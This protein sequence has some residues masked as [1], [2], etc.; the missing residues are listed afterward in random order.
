[1]TPL[2][3]D[4]GFQTLNRWQQWQGQGFNYDWYNNTYYWGVKL[5]NSP[6]PAA[7]DVWSSPWFNTWRLENQAPAAPALAAPAAGFRWASNAPPMLTINSNAELEPEGDPVSFR[8]E[9]REPAANGVAYRSAW[10]PETTAAGPL[11]W[12]LPASAPLLEGEQYEWTVEAR[13][14]LW[15]THAYHSMGEPQLLDAPGAALSAAKFE[16]RLGVTSPSPT[17]ALGA[18]TVNLATGNVTTSVAT[19]A[20]AVLGGALGFDVHLQLARPGQRAAGPR[21]RRQRHRRRRGRRR[22]RDRPGRPGDRLLLV[23]R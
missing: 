5:A 7:S 10:T 21:P 20:V 12:A 17:Q 13:D 22:V 4:S 2:G 11:S 14:S 15:R 9:V 3:G 8:F 16:Q 18:A 19:P 1:M 6:N 23:L